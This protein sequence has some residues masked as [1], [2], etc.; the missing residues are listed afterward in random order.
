MFKSVSKYDGAVCAGL[1]LVTS[2]M[3]TD[4]PHC[5]IDTKEWAQ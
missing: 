1:S 2:P 5:V 3:C 4:L